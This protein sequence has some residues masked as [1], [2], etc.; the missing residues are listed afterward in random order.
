MSSNQSSQ[1][2]YKNMQQELIQL[3]SELGRRTSQLSDLHQQTATTS[4]NL[5]ADLK[6]AQ[7]QLTQLQQDKQNIGTDN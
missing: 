6:L 7:Q 4:S 5:K 1:E 3:K 2:K